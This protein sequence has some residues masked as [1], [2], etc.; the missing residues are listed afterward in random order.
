M[1][2]CSVRGSSFRGGPRDGRTGLPGGPR[3]TMAAHAA[4]ARGHRAA[5]VA[6]S[7]DAE[8]LSRD[9]GD[10][11]LLP[12]AGFLVAD[13]AAQVFGEIQ[14]GG[15]G[16]LTERLAEDAAAV[17]ERHGARDQFGE[18]LAVETGGTRM[19][20]AYVRAPEENLA[21]QRAARR[22]VE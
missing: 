20:P 14:H 5:D 2:R 16:E 6:I 21:E 22:P 1:R 11:E 3:C 15:E 12:A 7:D 9:F 17:G 10:V 8:G 18:Q 19:H 13:H 4:C